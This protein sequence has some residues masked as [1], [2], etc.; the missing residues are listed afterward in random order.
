MTVMM[1]LEN[2]DIAINPLNKDILLSPRTT[3]VLFE[4]KPWQN[5]ED[6]FLT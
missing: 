5:A 2:T 4:T 1:V 3:G 6:A